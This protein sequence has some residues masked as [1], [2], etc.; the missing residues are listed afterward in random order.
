MKKQE[1][2]EK[3]G[4]EAY[5]ALLLKN[6]E[7]RENNPDKEKERKTVYYQKHK[8]ERNRKSKEWY[9]NNFDKMKAIKKKWYEENLEKTKDNF[10]EWYNNGNGKNKILENN[11][12]WKERHPREARAHN[13]VQNYL[14]YDKEKGFDTSNNI[15]SSWIV[16]NIFSGQKCAYCGD[17]DWTHLGCDR[18]DNNKPHTDDNVVCSCFICNADRANGYTVEEFKQYR[19]LHPRA[20]DIPKAPAIQL[21]ETGA[22]K[23]RAIPVG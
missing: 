17:Q 9:L 4:E 7:W 5:K 21:S 6:K 1:Y 10:K 8:E 15:S 20:C 11:K 16:D 22:I 19:S 3:Y 18:I 13:I 12:K 14:R 23:K 2:I